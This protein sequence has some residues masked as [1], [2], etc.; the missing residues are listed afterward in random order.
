MNSNPPEN[1]TT[2]DVSEAQ[3][4][5]TESVE[6]HEETKENTEVV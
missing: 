2:T 4:K 3:K 6:K 5:E 1:K